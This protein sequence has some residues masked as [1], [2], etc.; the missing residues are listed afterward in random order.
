MDK[1]TWQSQRGEQ[2]IFVSLIN[3]EPGQIINSLNRLAYNAVRMD[4]A[5][6]IHH[7]THPSASGPCLENAH[8]VP[9]SMGTAQC[10]SALS[11]RLGGPLYPWWSYRDFPY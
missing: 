10:C 8:F 1:W 3:L 6:A 5:H 9:R 4:T 11:R 7:Q 2:V